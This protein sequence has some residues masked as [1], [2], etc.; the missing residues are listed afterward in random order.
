MPFPKP[1]CL[2]PNRGFPDGFLLVVRPAKRLSVIQIVLAAHAKRKDVIM[3]PFSIIA[4]ALRTD[5]MIAFFDFLPQEFVAYKPDFNG[6]LRFQL[7]P[8]LKNAARYERFD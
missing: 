6:L 7:N 1:V 4:P 5:S 8:S 3:M 2:G